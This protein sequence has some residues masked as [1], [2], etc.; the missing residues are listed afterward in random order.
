MNDP[1]MIFLLGIVTGVLG[2]PVIAIGIVRWVAEGEPDVNGDPE[3]DAGALRTFK[4]APPES[5]RKP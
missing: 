1:L 4:P 5:E 3:K 2:A